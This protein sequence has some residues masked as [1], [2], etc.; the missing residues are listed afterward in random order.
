MIRFKLSPLSFIYLLVHL[1]LYSSDAKEDYYKI[2]GISRKASDKEIK[3]AY[4]KLALKW[5]PDKNKGNTEK[6]TKKFASISEAYETLK[7]PDKRKTYD[8]TVEDI[9]F[10]N[11]KPQDTGAFNKQSFDFGND[12]L[13]T[14]NF[15]G[16]GQQRPNSKPNFPNFDFGGFGKSYGSSFNQPK[17]ESA[18]N[19][20]SNSNINILYSNKYPDNTSKYI[21][22]V[23]YYY[24]TDSSAVDKFKNL[25]KRLKIYGIKAGSVSCKSEKSICYS[26]KINSESSYG[27]IYEGKHYFQLKEN[28]DSLFEFVNTTLIKKSKLIKSHTQLKE[29][30]SKDCLNRVK[31]GLLLIKDVNSASPLILSSL[32]QYF[33]NSIKDSKFAV[34][35]ILSSNKL[36]TS[37]FET[38]IFP[39]LIL[40]CGHKKDL[41]YKVY[42]KDLKDYPSILEFFKEYLT[43]PNKCKQIENEFNQ[44]EYH[45]NTLLKSFSKLSFDDLKGKS[46]SEL[47]DVSKLL[48]IDT[49]AFIE[50]SEYISSILKQ[51]KK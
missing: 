22:V 31:I 13:N 39:Q 51:F 12:F 3:N 33:H 46:L 10:K 48:K 18:I 30:Y 38:N 5:H 14:F 11:Y 50:K 40:V 35:E 6:A 32:S 20:Y 16:S 49:T 27:I 25:A 34:G 42:N 21:W 24:K 36:I 37:E 23:H 29:F 19:P 2:L 15:G 26:I 9:P 17:Q 41:L 8:M 47:R 45:K 1:Y 4:R 43:I 28:V 44:R 7:D